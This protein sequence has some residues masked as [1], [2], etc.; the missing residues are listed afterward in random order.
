MNDDQV[1]PPIP[2]EKAQVLTTYQDQRTTL[3]IQ[4][5]QCDEKEEYD[6]KLEE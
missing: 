6:E 3:S 5:F 2:T 4:V 1:D